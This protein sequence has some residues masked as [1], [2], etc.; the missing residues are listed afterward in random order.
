MILAPRGVGVG[1]RAMRAHVKDAKSAK[2]LFFAF[3]APFAFFA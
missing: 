1:A 3:F 2:D